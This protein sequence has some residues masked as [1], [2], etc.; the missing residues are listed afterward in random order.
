M[1]RFLF[2][3]ARWCVLVSLCSGVASLHA[4]MSLDAAL[5]QRAQVVSS[6]PQIAVSASPASVQDVL[7]RSFAKADVVFAGEVTAIE[8]GDSVVRV[9]FR[10]DDAVRGVSGGTYTLREW[11]GLWDATS[12]RYMIGQR[13]LMLLH[14]PSVAGFA[15][16]VDG[17]GAVMLQGG[18]VGQTADLRWLATQMAVTD[19]A[20]LAPVRA[21]RAAGGAVMTASVMQARQALPVEV[22]A[23]PVA[24]VS[25]SASAADAMV[26]GAIVMDLLH[27]WQRDAQGVSR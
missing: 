22:A 5:R 23:P 6:T 11:A 15:S 9:L 12:D 1:G 7:Q 13:Y 10:V 24:T 14:A 18:G 26:D 17:D 2:A 21:L 25:T 16:P 3:G 8:R 27:A 4:Q 19:D 20:R